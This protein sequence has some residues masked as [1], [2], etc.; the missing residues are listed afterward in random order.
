MIT[1]TYAALM[2]LLFVALSVRVIRAR[3]SQKVGIGTGNNPLVERAM[4]VHANFAEYA[5]FTLLL[6]YFAE[7]AGAHAFVVHLLGA[8]LLAGRCIH[9]VGVSRAPE[10]FRLR[11]AGMILTLSTILLASASLLVLA[12]W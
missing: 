2:G 3:R 8:I 5:P 11:V 6:I 7:M 9:A 10:D 4:R 12:A 1:M